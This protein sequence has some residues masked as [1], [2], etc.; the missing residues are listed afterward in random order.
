[1]RFEIQRNSK[2]LIFD[3]DLH[4]LK[5]HGTEYVSGKDGILIYDQT[6][7]VRADEVELQMS[8]N[9]ST[10]IPALRILSIAYHPCF[11]E[12]P[13]V[14]SQN[15]ITFYWNPSRLAAFY[16][17]FSTDELEY[18][19]REPVI[20]RA[21]DFLCL[22]TDS[23]P[24]KEEYLNRMLEPCKLLGFY[25]GFP[26]FDSSVGFAKLQSR[27]GIHVGREDIMIS[28]P[29]D[30]YESDVY[31]LAELLSK[32]TSLNYSK[33]KNRVIFPKEPGLLDV[34]GAGEMK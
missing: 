5:V 23:L 30:R 9:T 29:L 3:S 16:N 25:Q 21:V 34:L 4:G 6:G 24:L 14:E 31:E 7:E 19:D 8:T 2:H 15:N 10:L 22:H 28:T 12:R 32:E 17:Q 13:V 11:D 27:L 18:R 20:R 1:M 33:K 26:I